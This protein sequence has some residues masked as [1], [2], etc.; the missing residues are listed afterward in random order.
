MYACAVRHPS[1]DVLTPRRI[2]P[3]CV[4]N[5]KQISVLKKVS[6]SEAVEMEAASLFPL[7]PVC[8][9][10]ARRQKSLVHPHPFSLARGHSRRRRLM[11]F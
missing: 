1:S 3:L 5:G 6:L 4:H 8:E 10:E 2:V 11:L 9:S 7:S